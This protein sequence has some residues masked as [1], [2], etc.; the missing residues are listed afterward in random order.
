MTQVNPQIIYII[1][2]SLSLENHSSK[3]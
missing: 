1:R 3:E 2:K